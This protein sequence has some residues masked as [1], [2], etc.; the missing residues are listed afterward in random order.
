MPQSCIQ[1]SKAN[2][3]IGAGVVSVKAITNGHRQVFSSPAHSV[4]LGNNAP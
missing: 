4:Q 1:L 2:P 3:K